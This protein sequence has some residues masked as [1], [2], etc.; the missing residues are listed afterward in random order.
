L[1]LDARA[2]DVSQRDSLRQLLI[3]ARKDVEN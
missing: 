2:L 3:A 1:Q